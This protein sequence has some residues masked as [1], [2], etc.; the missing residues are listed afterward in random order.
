MPRTLSR[1]AFVKTIGAA[2]A[3]TS[4]GSRLRA[5]PAGQV[6]GFDHV[7][8]PMQNTDAM[9]A[10]Y[11]KLGFQMRESAQAVSVYVGAQMINL[12][13]PTLWQNS[14]FTLRAPRTSGRHRNF[15][16]SGFGFRSTTSAM[17]GPRTGANFSPCPLPPKNAASGRRAGVHDARHG[18]ILPAQRNRPR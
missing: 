1:R 4:R 10:F 9:L 11:R 18:D 3:A 7:A 8:L 16:A 5:Q 12:H 17:I 13:R 14:S 6:S 15:A 2:G